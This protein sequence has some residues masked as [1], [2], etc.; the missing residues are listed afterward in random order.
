MTCSYSA[1]TRRAQIRLVLGVKTLISVS[2]LDKTSFLMP[3]LSFRLV[4]I[5]H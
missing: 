3:L 4:K 1:K 2:S 5:K